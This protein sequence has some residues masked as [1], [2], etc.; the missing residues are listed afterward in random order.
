MNTIEYNLQAVRQTIAHAARAAQRRPE[1]ITLL[2]VS[3]S[4]PV[5][6]I[7]EAYQAGQS[8]FGESYLQEALRKM[9]AL[10]D[11]PLEW[12]FI[13]PVQSNKSAAIAEHFSWVHGVDRFRVAERLS[14]QRP[15]Q[16]PKLNVCIQ[17]NIGGEPSKS[18]VLPDEVEEL[19]MAVAE[20]QNLKLRGLMVIPPPAEGLVA[21]RRSFAMLHELM[22]QLNTS[23]LGLDTLSMGMS[24]DLEAAVL[25]GATI[26]RVGTAIF[27]AR[28]KHR[29][30]I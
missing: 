27:G 1:E 16:M 25:E 18:G 29:D 23:G 14:A 6:A 11:L 9:E 7:R 5:S 13:G 21:Q 28:T 3:K 22:R 10:R 2:A 8:A 15:E 26:V 12:H 24:H 19:A 20:L 30:S 4:F 17:V